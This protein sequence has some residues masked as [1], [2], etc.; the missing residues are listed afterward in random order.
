MLIAKK[1]VRNMM[2]EG[3]FRPLVF[4]FV[5]VCFAKLKR[6]ASKKISYIRIRRT[7]HYMY[8]YRTFRIKILASNETMISFQR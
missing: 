8:V 3:K 4:E 1:V 2:K 7:A 5:I 6:V